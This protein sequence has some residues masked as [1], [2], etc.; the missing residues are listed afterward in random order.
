MLALPIRARKAAGVEVLCVGYRVPI[1]R[2]SLEDGSTMQKPRK[3]LS[4]RPI[5]KY[6]GWQAVADRASS[7]SAGGGGGG[8]GGGSGFAAKAEHRATALS[9]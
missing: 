9:R 4:G 3:V 6:L 7:D 2:P 1:A 5:A 8:G